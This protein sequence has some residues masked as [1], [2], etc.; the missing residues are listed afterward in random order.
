MR[1]W[2]NTHL[3]KLVWFKT[4]VRKKIGIPAYNHEY[5]H[6]V[7]CDMSSML[8]KSQ[9]ELKTILK[10]DFES[11]DIPSFSMMHYEWTEN[12]QYWFQFAITG[13]IDI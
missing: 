12:Q 9:K 7:W 10:Q 2:K 1:K 5:D 11:Q 3:K 8:R 13:L 6:T 4:Y